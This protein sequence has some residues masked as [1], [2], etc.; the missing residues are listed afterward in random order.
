MIHRFS[1]CATVAL[2]V[3]AGPASA[4]SRH[5]KL[6]TRVDSLAR[7]ALADWLTP[8][9]SI[10][11]S[12][13]NDVL[14]SRGYG[15]ARLMDSTPASPETVY[16]I[17]SITKQFT[18][19]AIMQL[20]E[21]R[22]I[23]LKDEFWVHLPEYA[24]RQRF[25]IQQL[26]NHTSGI[27]DWASVPDFAGRNQSTLDL[28]PQQ[29]LVA[30]ANRSYNFAPGQKF[31][32]SNAGYYL[33]GL[34]V[35]KI[36]GERYGDYIRTHLLDP[37]LMINSK[38]CTP[39]GPHRARGYRA[40]DSMI[41]P[42]TPIGDDEMYAAAGLCSTAAD[43]LKWPRALS[44]GS[45]INNFSWKQMIEPA[46]LADGSTVSYGYG[47]TLGRLGKHRFV[48]HGGAV[49]GFA[50]QISYYPDAD[51][52]VVVLA[53]SEQAVPRRIADQIARMVLG[54]VEPRVKDLPLAA[55][56]FEKYVGAYDLAGTAIQV[57]ERA[58]RLMMRVDDGGGSVLL[59]Q[60]SNEFATEADPTTTLYFRMSR[61]Y[62]KSLVFTTGGLSLNA[63]RLD[64][65]S[66]HSR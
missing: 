19:A 23:K 31:A 33:L 21:K 29:F 50:S 53:N 28:T 5:K 9:M 27:P 48:G 60:G 64:A 4:Q 1:L 22:R 58:G 59:Y 65:V 13:G 17:A 36:S 55:S 26:L 7:K 2:L 25:T 47:V 63:D 3:L 62:A 6:N 12:R 42:A 8:G 44:D 66:T 32:Y 56:D 18:A 15:I 52:T 16:P 20:A 37:A 10:A 54:M 51:V 30:F 46:E 57:Y 45:L 61:G 39:D 35:E 14:V 24:T 43:L 49:R 34:L 40:L 41:V 11:V 38:Y